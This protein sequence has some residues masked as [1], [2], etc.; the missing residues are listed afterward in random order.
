MDDNDEDNQSGDP[1]NDAYLETLD[2]GREDAQFAF[3]EQLRV[4][5]EESKKAGKIAQL[6]GVIL[7]IGATI[8][9]AS[10]GDQLYTIHLFVWLGAGFLILGFISGIAGQISFQVPIGISE[11]GIDGIL[12]TEPSPEEYKRWS[13][14]HHKKWL[15]STRKK[16]NWRVKIVRG[17]AI[18]SVM[19]LIFLLTGTYLTITP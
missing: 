19:G 9:L 5:E 2:T 8:L 13:L 3:N 14:R 12:E 18:S 17:S 6:N 15:T 16:A 4:F 11:I 10:G 7:S 1:S